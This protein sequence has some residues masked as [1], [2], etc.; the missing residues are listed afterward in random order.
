[1][2]FVSGATQQTDSQLLAQQS[3]QLQTHWSSLI[4]NGDTVKSELIKLES[5]WQGNASAEFQNAANTWI[6]GYGQVLDGLRTLISHVD[7]ANQE[8]QDSEQRRT[9]TSSNSWSQF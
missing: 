7:A 9:S 2:S 3:Q 5:V 6:Q 1:M 4:Q 8:S